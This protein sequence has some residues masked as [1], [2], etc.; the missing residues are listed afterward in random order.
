VNRGDGLPREFLLSVK[1]PEWRGR[2]EQE[3]CRDGGAICHFGKVE[4]VVDERWNRERSLSSVPLHSVTNPKSH[5]K[6]SEGSIC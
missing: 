4:T 1:L 2:C 3:R 6:P 5:A